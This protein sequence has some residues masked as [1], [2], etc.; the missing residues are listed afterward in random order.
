MLT[1][2]RMIFTESFWFHCRLL[3]R[4]HNFKISLWDYKDLNKFYH[5][6]S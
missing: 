6:W 5:M 3:D 2:K 4:E 1:D